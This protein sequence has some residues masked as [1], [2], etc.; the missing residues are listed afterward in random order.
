[1]DIKEDYRIK[2]CYIKL[3]GSHSCATL[4]HIWKLLPFH[5]IIMDL[6]ALHG[7]AAKMKQDESSL[8]QIQS[9]LVASQKEIEELGQELEEQI[10]AESRKRHWKMLKNSAKASNSLK[11]HSK[12]VPTQD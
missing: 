4:G 11:L 8:E 7:I 2:G 3:T 10:R 5:P 9:N 1:M 12:K 6:P